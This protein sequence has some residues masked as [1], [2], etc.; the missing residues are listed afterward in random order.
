[1]LSMNESLEFQNVYKNRNERLPPEV[2]R[3]LF[4]KNLPFKISDEQLY[5][6]FGR[7]GAVRQIR[8]F[9]FS[10]MCAVHFLYCARMIACYGTYI[11]CDC[12]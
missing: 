9:S 11:L 5:E 2:N 8:K 4:V 6:L 10:C 7:Y 3:I 12:T 1:M